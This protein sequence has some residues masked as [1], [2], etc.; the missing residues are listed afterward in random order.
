MYDITYEYFADPSRT[1]GMMRK[2]LFA[3]PQPADVGANAESYVSTAELYR[4][5]HDQVNAAVGAAV[6]GHRGA[7]A[8]AS[9]AFIGV[10]AQRI[11]EAADEAQRAFSAVESGTRHYQAAR[12]KMP[13][14][15][16]D[17]PPPWWEVAGNVQFVPIVTATAY[18]I[19]MN[20]Y[21]GSRQQAVEA[22][23]TY[24][25]SANGT[26]RAEF[27]QFTT[28]VPTLDG[29][30]AATP[31]G[32]PAFP[33]GGVGTAVAPPALPPGGAGRA[34][35]PV[36]PGGR[37][38]S[39][40]PTS[41]VPRG[42]V[43][44]VVPPGGPGGQPVPGQNGAP[45]PAPRVP[46]GVDRA[47]PGFPPGANAG[48]PGQPR[49]P[50]AGGAG[51]GPTPG[52]AGPTGPGGAGNPARPGPPARP[53][54]GPPGASAFPFLPFGGGMGRQEEERRRPSWLVQDDPEEFWLGD[55][56][57]HVPA[58]ITGPPPRPA[59]ED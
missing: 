8:D 20:T 31:T 54:A 48:L 1:L 12:N 29:A 22:M 34:Q 9:R 41:P 36:G 47:G 57:P 35:P 7:A 43:P 23:N 6:E 25:E 26:I 2:Q 16:W 32:A 51:P 58:V 11:A 44:P 50:G 17:Q 59:A 52:G 46:A 5:I 4:S 38:P 15:G 37:R 49:G 56:P 14:D 55:L 21:N 45:R 28:T 13:T 53:A 3:A 18:A 39:G 24:Q 40:V 42:Q 10:H 30:A 19:E 33:G 27:Q